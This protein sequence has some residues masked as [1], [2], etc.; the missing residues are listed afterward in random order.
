MVRPGA[1]NDSAIP[2]KKRTARSPLALWQ[3]AVSMSMAPHMRLKTAAALV[4]RE[5]EGDR[6]R[7]WYRRSR[8]Q[9]TWMP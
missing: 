7:D 8:V 9:L 1:I 3:A 4:S 2:R 5:R 6:Q